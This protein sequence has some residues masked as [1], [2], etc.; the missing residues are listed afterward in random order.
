[1]GTNNVAVSYALQK[2]YYKT[3]KNLVEKNMSLNDILKELKIIGLENKR[4]KIKDLEEYIKKHLGLEWDKDKNIWKKTSQIS[5]LTD[6]YEDAVEISCD[7]ALLSLTEND[8]KSMLKDM[9]YILSNVNKITN[10]V[11]RIVRDI[12]T[13][14]ATI[15]PRYDTEKKDEK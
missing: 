13:I 12:D 14:V 10:D 5:M 7:N 11:D 15:K 4:S 8:T 6:Y 9:K 2:I 1:M 3:V